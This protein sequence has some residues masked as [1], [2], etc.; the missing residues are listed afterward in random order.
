M[1]VNEI[2]YNRD[3]ENGTE[4]ESGSECDNNENRSLPA[5]HHGRSPLFLFHGGKKSYDSISQTSTLELALESRVSLLE[6]MV[7]VA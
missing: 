2:I 3:T 7:S 1:R 5:R 6:K 4:G